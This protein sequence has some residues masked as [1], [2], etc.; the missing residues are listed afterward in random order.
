MV[1]STFD[2]HFR[3]QDDNCCVIKFYEK[4]KDYYCKLQNYVDEY[5]FKMTRDG[6][7]SRLGSASALPVCFIFDF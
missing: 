1:K 5:V 4:T 6:L 2:G 3:G 7:V